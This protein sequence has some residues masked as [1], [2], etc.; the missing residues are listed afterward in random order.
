MSVLVKPLRLLS[1]AVYCHSKLLLH[2]CQ[3]LQLF[4]P[5]SH[6]QPTKRQLSSAAPPTVS[7]ICNNWF[8][9]GRDE[10]SGQCGWSQVSM[11]SVAT[12][13]H[14]VGAIKW[15]DVVSRRCRIEYE[16]RDAAVRGD[17]ETQKKLHSFVLFLG[18]L[19][20]N[21]EVKRSLS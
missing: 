15:K 7:S 14:H 4:V 18:E 19:Y 10:I 16:Q 21:L 20:L 6:C 5:S 17:A 9:P 2:G 3:A 8:T 12:W 11:Q 1:V 13:Y